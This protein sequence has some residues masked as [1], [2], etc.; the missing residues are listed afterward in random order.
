MLLEG[1][2]IER[3]GDPYE[4]ARRYSELAISGTPARDEILS[5]DVYHPVNLADIWIG[6][7]Q[8]DTTP[9]VSE[10][11]ELR[12]HA[13]IETKEAI[14]KAT[15]RFEIRNQN[16]A[17]IFSPPATDLRGGE[18]IEAGERLHIEAMVE[19]R[20]TPDVYSLHCAVNRRDEGDNDKA[21]SDAKS[22]DFAIPGDRY[23]GQG[24]L[25]LESSVHIEDTG[26]GRLRAPGGAA[27]LMTTVTETPS[28][29]LR[30][31]RGPAA[32]GGEAKRFFQLL[33]LISKTELRTRY[34][35]AAFG[36]AWA[37]VEPLLIFGV[38]YAVF[39][40]VGRFGGTEPHYPAMLLMNIML[41]RAI[42]AS[43]TSRATRLSWR[44][45][46]SSARRSSRGSSSRSRS[47][48]RRCSCSPPTRSSSSS[49]CSS[50]ASRRCGPGCCS[51]SSF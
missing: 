36:M 32:F 43:S 49:S 5:D 47:S 21:L 50:T 14:E 38:M 2:R 39:S 30:E 4:C 11:E 16:R 29:P 35:G 15:F 9:I 41:Y 51:P 7:L 28:I 45:R 33:W 3:I 23:R 26:Q 46:G 40:S 17:R 20:L 13:V 22:I 34:Q 18:R 8:G 19:N 12:L 25:S 31:V 24:L 48:S 42:F 6:D 44:A 27:R 37:V 10:S 1:G